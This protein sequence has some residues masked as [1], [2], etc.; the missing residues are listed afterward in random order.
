MAKFNRCDI[1]GKEVEF[2]W[3]VGIRTWGRW[4]EREVCVSCYNKTIRFFYCGKAPHLE[5]ADGEKEN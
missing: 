2:P 4:L 3:T 1:C 5:V